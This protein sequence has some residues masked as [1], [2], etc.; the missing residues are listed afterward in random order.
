MRIAFFNRAMSKGGAEKMMA[1]VLN[2]VAPIS[3]EI[4]LIQYSTE[5]VDYDFPSNVR[6]ERLM[7][8]DGSKRNIIQKIKEFLIRVKQLR[9][10]LL[11]N[12]VEVLCT[13]GY[14]YTL[15]GVLATQGTSVKILAS[16]RRSPQDNGWPWTYLSKLIYKKCDCLV[17]QL[18][19]ASDYYN[20]IS[21]SKKCVIPNPYIKGESRVLYDVKNTRPEIVMAASRLEYVKG[22]DVGIRAMRKIVDKHPDYKL[23]IFGGGDFNTLYSGLISELG[24]QDAIVYK[25]HSKKILDE[26]VNSRIFLLPSRVEGI[27]NMLMEAMGL[28]MPCVA[29]DCTPGGARL[30]IGENNEYGQ[31]VPVDDVDATADAILKYID[32]ID[33][34][35]KQGICA[36]SVSYR[37]SMEKI[38][39]QWVDS[40][41]YV[42]K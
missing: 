40:F 26:I 24:L 7:I 20:N 34:L 15:M 9:H 19:E 36:Q 38:A 27:P 5:S 21:E 16:E 1:F 35:Q 28:G 10:K 39:K 11:E 13:F 14:F 2:S 6:H 3:D 31:L 42:I 41:N 12:N 25:G 22:F 30:L 32:N 17:F 37:F 29:A 33:Y 18:Q 4:F 8:D 23:I